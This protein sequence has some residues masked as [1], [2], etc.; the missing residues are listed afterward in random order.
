MPDDTPNIAVSQT[1]DL[2]SLINEHVGRIEKLK[3]EAGKYKEMLDDIFQN[4][5]TYQQHDKLVK[6]AQKVRNGTKKQ[7]M[8]MPQA[9]DLVARIQEFKNM[10]KESN[11]SLSGYLQEYQRS[12]GLFQ[13]ETSDGEVREIIYTARLIKAS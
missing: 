6:E 10:I 12:T 2:T 1:L 9:A 13:I 7:L 5:P 8:K 3:I 11:E 4:D